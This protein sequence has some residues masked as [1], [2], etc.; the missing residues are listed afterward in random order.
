MGNLQVCVGQQGG[1]E[2]AIHA[3]REI[4]EEPECEAVLMVDA[5]NAF[6]TLNRR[7]TIQ[8]IKVKCP[9]F[10]KYVENTFKEPA[11]LYVSDKKTTRSQVIV[12]DEG[13]IQGDP[14]S[15]AVYAIGLS[16]LQ[17]EIRHETTEIKQVALC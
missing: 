2:A 14:I 4:Y 13:T 3:M 1:C 15:M 8:N 11:K 16:K 9:I 10:A 7:A 12:S 17:M 6:N 5:S